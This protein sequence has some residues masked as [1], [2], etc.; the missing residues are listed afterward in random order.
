[1]KPKIIF[2]IVI[3]ALL[4]RLYHI[5]FPVSGWHAWRQ[6]DTAAM[7]R[8]FYEHGFDIRYPQIDWGGNSSSVLESEFPVYP[9]LVSLRYAALG[10]SDVWGRV[11]ALVCSLITIYALYRL[12]GKYLSESIALWSAF[13]YAIIPLNAYYGRAFMPESAMMMCSVLGIW[14]FGEWLDRGSLRHFFLSALFIALAV[15]LKIPALYLGL[16]LL[17]LAWLRFGTS[18]FTSRMLWLYAVVCPASGYTMVL[19][20]APIVPGIRTYGRNLGAGAGKWGSLDI[21]LTPKILQ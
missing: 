7:A 20:C 16:P 17:F 10:A 11:V 12:I 6:A 1:M 5:D 3:L 9:Y 8:N 2:G 14:W 18:I 19:S 21:I 4:L 15:L 13:M